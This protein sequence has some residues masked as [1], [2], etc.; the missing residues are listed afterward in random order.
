MLGKLFG[1]LKD[2]ENLTFF[3]FLVYVIVMT[4]VVGYFLV[5]W[6]WQPLPK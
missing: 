6:C 3:M 4:H 2:G 5:N 1:L